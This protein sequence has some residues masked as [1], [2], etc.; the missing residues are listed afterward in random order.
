MSKAWKILRQNF[1][2][3]GKG[4]FKTVDAMKVAKMFEDE[5]ERLKY[6]LKQ[7][8]RINFENFSENDR[9]LLKSNMALTREVLNIKNEN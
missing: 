7:W 6:V 3:D 5:N 4:R 1:K 8:V 2:S 9:R